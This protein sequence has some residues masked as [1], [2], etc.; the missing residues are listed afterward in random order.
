MK[1]ALCVQI[2]RISNMSVTF[3]ELKKPSVQGTSPTKMLLVDAH[4]LEYTQHD[5]SLN[6]Y[7]HLVR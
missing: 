2:P 5:H 4:V 6:P 1:E 3:E 7:Y